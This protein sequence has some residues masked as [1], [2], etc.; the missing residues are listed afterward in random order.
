M[1]FSFSSS[2]LVI[3]FLL[4]MAA[5]SKL[6]CILESLSSRSLR[7][8]SCLLAA[9]SFLAFS[10]FRAVRFSPSYLEEEEGEEEA[11]QSDLGLH[12]NPINPIL[13]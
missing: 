9:A 3:F 2:S 1:A 4:S 11:F 12:P 6:I 7:S 8:C 13:F 10:A 5:R